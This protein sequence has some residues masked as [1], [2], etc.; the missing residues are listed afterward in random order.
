VKSSVAQAAMIGDPV[1]FPKVRKLVD[2]HFRD[3]FMTVDLEEQEIMEGMLQSNRC[4]HVVCTQGGESIAGLKRAMKQ[5]IVNK[6]Q[7]VVVD[8]TSHQ[9]KFSN[10]Q[11]MYFRDA[12]PPEYEISPQES[13]T[14]KPVHLGASSEEVAKFLNLM[15]K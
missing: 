11:D 6:N 14:N 1:S 8:S 3:L 12:F 5:G 7:T 4:G 13:F 10:F 2:Q 15:E 9:L